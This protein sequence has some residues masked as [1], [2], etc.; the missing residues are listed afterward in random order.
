VQA[1]IIQVPLFEHQPWN[2][3]RLQCASRNF[4]QPTTIVNKA[5]E[6]KQPAVDPFVDLENRFKQLA[7]GTGEGEEAKGGTPTA[8]HSR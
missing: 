4:Q 8:A 5:P 2:M 7:V 1:V 6:R 3:A